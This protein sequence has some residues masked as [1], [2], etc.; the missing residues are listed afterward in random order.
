VRKQGIVTTTTLIA[1]ANIGKVGI[2]KTL[3]E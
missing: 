1:G 3:Y 2:I